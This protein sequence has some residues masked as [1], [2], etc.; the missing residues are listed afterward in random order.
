M[1][2]ILASASPRR[3]EL[4]SATGMHFEVVTS[5]AEEI[6]D[7]AIPLDELCEKNAELKALAVAVDHPDA[8][9]IGADTLVWIEG[10]P[11]GKP[12]DLDEA[13]AMLRKLS[14]RPHTVCTGVCVV[15]P[16]GRVQRFHEL[17]AVRF[18]ELDD[19][20]IE[21]YFE[22]TNPLDKAGAYGIQD[23]GEMIVEGIEG[24]FDNVMG[25]PVARLV[26]MLGAEN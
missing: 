20:T 7:A 24:A 15:F 21:A 14:G 10:E 26:E 18:R 23:S 6:H 5:P 13:R 3:R 4:L 2:V 16:G 1:N 17:T 22:K 19:A 8:A 9:V 11:L 12:K 25:L